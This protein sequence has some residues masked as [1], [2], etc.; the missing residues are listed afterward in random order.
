LGPWKRNAR[1]VLRQI[2]QIFVVNLLDDSGLA[3]EGD[4]DGETDHTDA[5]RADA[6]IDQHGVD[7][8]AGLGHGRLGLLLHCLGRC[9]LGGERGELRFH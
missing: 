9:G 5:E 7:L 4:P 1:H 6:A 8:H 3:A 2:I